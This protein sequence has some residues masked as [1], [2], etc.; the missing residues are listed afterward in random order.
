MEQLIANRLTRAS[1]L[2]GTDVFN[3]QGQNL[4][5]IKDV[6]VDTVNGKIIYAVLSFGGFLGLGDKYFAVP[7]QA[8]TIDRN[9]NLILDVDKE[10]L[11]NAPGFDK[12]NWPT[13]Y[14]RTFTEDV[15]SYYNQTYIFED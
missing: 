15:Y 9:N 5:H 3:P 4:G 11:K 10:R 12:D 14:D 1:D 7:V 8:F 6:M 2:K 13:S